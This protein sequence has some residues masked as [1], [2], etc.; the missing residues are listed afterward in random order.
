MI[1]SVHKLQN[2]SLKRTA[3]FVRILN[4]PVKHK[5]Y[6]QRLDTLI[7]HL[8]DKRAYLLQHINFLPI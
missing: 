5:S 4:P 2:D 6:K 1:K 3:L 7:V 8:T